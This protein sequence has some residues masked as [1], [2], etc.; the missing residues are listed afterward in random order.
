MAAPDDCLNLHDFL[1]ERCVCVGA[2]Q[3]FRE[4]PEADQAWI[5]AVF[6]EEQTFLGLVNDRQ[7]AMF[8]D[9][10]FA[11]LLMHRPVRQIDESTPVDEVLCSMEA[12][13]HEFEAVLDEQGVFVGAVSR[14]SIVNA[15]VRQEQEQR[16]RLESLLADYKRELENHEIAS[17]VFDATSEGIMVTDA[18]QRIR[19]VNR[20]FCE[21]TGFSEAEALGQTPAI[22]QSG[23]QDEAFY[24][25]MWQSLKESGAWE[26]EIWNRRKNGEL[27]PEFLHINA[28]HDDEGEVLHYAGVFSDA[29]RHREMRDQIDRLA[30]HDA[31]TDLPNR[32]LF[33][34]RLEHGISQARQEDEGL[35]LLFI[36]IDRFKEVN[37]TIGHRIGDLLLASVADALQEV[38]RESDTV[39]RM[40]GDE[41]A[42]LVQQQE[43]ELDKLSERMTDRFKRLFDIDGHSL[44]VTVSVGVSR[45]PV[46]AT[47]AQGLLVAAESA[48]YRAKEDGGGTYHFYSASSHRHFIDQ[49]RMAADLRQAIESDRIRVAWQ[50]QVDMASGCIVGAEALARWEPEPGRS[51]S[52][53]RFV[54]VAERTGQ[55]NALADCVMRRAF[56]DMRAMFDA[57][58]LEQRPF[59]FAVN[60]SP[61]QLMHDPVTGQGSNV[62][63]GRVHALIRE[64]RLD[65]WH[66]ELELTESALSSRDG[67]EGDLQAL[68]EAGIKIS[69]DDFGTGCSNLA[70]I[71]KLPISKI[72]LD[73]S[74]VRNLEDDPA[75]REIATAVL[76]MASAM[77]LD[78]VA[79]GVETN[80]QVR[81]LRQMGCRIAQGFLYS[82]PVPANDLQELLRASMPT[83]ARLPDQEGLRRAG[84]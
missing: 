1:C 64:F 59:R 26:G 4:L 39:A 84:G 29:S 70:T 78:V 5:F 75:D 27:Y 10:I 30:Y 73:R 37:D 12:Q 6:D 18:D 17:A 28:I 25:S 69:I 50:P 77:R 16:R 67:I 34:D 42:V 38:V 41:F 56:R 80:G 49:V 31:L 60:V 9:R 63:V 32:K 44:F 11:D 20:A 79:E 55:I 45:F 81:W 66:L 7:A 19:L 57:L 3:R 68:G 40:G 53:E 76:G 15:L 61:S 2:F 36:D 14:L 71:K 58:D 72:K 22:L 52:P 13:G 23:C 24:Q 51:V 83:C 8:P 48:M 33:L 74:L 62:L 43:G 46:D 82:R 65:G 47:D 21:T 54:E 35:A